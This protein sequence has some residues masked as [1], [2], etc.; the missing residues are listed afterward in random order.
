MLNII[1]VPKLFKVQK[2]KLTNIQKLNNIII[3]KKIRHYAPS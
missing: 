1:N 2:K 3:L